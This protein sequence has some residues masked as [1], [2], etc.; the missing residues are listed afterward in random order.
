M[1]LFYSGGVAKT[2]IPPIFE[3]ELLHV[4]FRHT[5]REGR[6][7]MVVPRKYTEWFSSSG[8]KVYV[9]WRTTTESDQLTG[10]SIPNVIVKVG[11]RKQCML[12]SCVSLIKVMQISNFVLAD[13]FSHTYATVQCRSVIHWLCYMLYTLFAQFIIFNRILPWMSMQEDIKWMICTAC[14]YNCYFCILLTIY[15]TQETL[16]FQF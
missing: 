13:G 3:I 10:I 15:T 5:Y 6:K 7:Q 9:R 8:E 11:H 12:S 1:S 2:N 4:L 14:F 16:K